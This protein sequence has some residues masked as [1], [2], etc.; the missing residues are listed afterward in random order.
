MRLARRLT[1][2]IARHK[3][4]L[5][6]CIFSTGW[7]A[8]RIGLTPRCW[9]SPHGVR[10][11]DIVRVLDGDTV[12]DSC[13]R[14]LRIV[15]I[16]TPERDTAWGPT[17]AEYTRTWLAAAPDGLTMRHC[18]PAP[19]DRYGRRLVRLQRRDGHDLSSDLLAAGWAYPLHMP[20]CGTPWQVDDLTVF[21]AAKA[22][23]RGMWQTWDPRPRN[24]GAALAE[25]GWLRVRGEIATVATRGK[26]K[27]LRLRG[28][29]GLSVTLSG[30]A[31]ELVL[32]VGDTLELEGWIGP[33]NPARMR[34]RDQQDIQVL[35][36]SSVRR[37]GSAD[38]D[39][40]R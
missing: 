24:V 2:A 11:V 13:D 23:G 18:K 17:A 5:F 35:A 21:R 22:A 8:D 14:R 28:G 36:V 38:K 39:P 7:A 6:V 15:G 9:Q 31:S 34:V 3:A 1:L 30:S 32:G 10:S 25:R 33:R 12:V 37:R 26:E 19:E 20:P 4:L 16:D 40:T 27:T 29:R